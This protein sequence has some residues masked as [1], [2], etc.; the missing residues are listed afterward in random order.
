MLWKTL[1]KMNGHRNL[2][3]RLSK[4]TQGYTG[5]M[6]CEIEKEK[7][8]DIQVNIYEIVIKFFHIRHN[9]I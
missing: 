9:L 4:V 5:Q 3:V 2:I 1:L 7:N 6:H 8:I